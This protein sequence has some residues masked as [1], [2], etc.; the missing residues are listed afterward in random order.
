MS[1]VT[2]TMA[3]QVELGFFRFKLLHLPQH[4]KITICLIHHLKN[5]GCLVIMHEVQH[6]L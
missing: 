5:G 3:Q 4:T 1:G 6:D 2:A